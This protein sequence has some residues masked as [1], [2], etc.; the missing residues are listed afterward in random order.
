MRKGLFLLA[1]VLLCGLVPARGDI[2]WIKDDIDAAFREAKVRKQ[3]LLIYF[4]T[5]W[6]SWCAQM[7][8]KVFS[9]DEVTD[10]SNAF[11]SL[12]LNCDRR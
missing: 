9:D 5:T 8:D 6:C 7:E 4:H 3:P 11:V 12:R 1:L 10:R 2:P